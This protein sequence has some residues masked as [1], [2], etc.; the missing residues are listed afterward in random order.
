MSAL[1]NYDR[2]NEP[3][4]REEAPLYGSVRRLGSAVGLATLS[5]LI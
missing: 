1:E 2:Q 3:V 4:V 5:V